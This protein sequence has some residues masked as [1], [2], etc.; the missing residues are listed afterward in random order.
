[1]TSSL[2]LRSLVVRRAVATAGALML[3]ACATLRQ[4]DARNEL[5]RAE[6]AF[7]QDSVDHGIRSAFIAHFAPDGLVFE[8]APVRVREVWPTRPAPG[9]PQRLRLDWSPRLV[10]VARAADLGFSTG[11]FQL[12][13]TMG[14]QPPVDGAFFSVWQR[15]QDGAWKVWLDM[16]ARNAGAQDD[17]AWVGPPAA[18]AR[19]QDEAAPTASA[20]S[21]LDRALSGLDPAAFADRLAVAAR[22]YRDGAPGAVGARWRETLFAARETAT[23]EPMEA[24]VSISG[25]LAGSYG[26]ITHDGAGAAPVSGYYVHVWIRDGGAWWLAA[27]AVVDER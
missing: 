25:D 15:Q 1:M 23:Y 26:R 2:A 24:R 18:P 6:H 4:D 8:P 10:Q 14:I 27:E 11:P 12:V 20:V 7:A 16:G 5:A 17:A 19:P 3:C 13:D 22:R 21:A 9:D